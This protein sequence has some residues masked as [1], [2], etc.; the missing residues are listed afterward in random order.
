MRKANH[1]ASV[2]LLAFMGAVPSQAHALSNFK[3]QAGIGLQAFIPTGE[4][5]KDV[6]T[7]G[8]GVSGD[9]AIVYKNHVM[10]SLVFA[11]T[12]SPGDPVAG[13][14]ATDASAS[15]I[16]LPIA[17]TIQVAILTNRPFKPYVGVGWGAYYVRE[18]L[19]FT[20]PP[21]FGQQEETQSATVS[22]F[23]LMAGVEQNKP[24][25][26]FGEL[27]YNKASVFE[28]D[29]AGNGIAAGGIRLRIGYRGW[30]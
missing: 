3:Y 7:F 2:L 1:T 18:K 8:V 10:L 29:D 4:E 28:V 19:S 20:G 14:L 25:R 6:Y 27:W 15:F 22:C 24:R 26:I 12:Y 5:I 17:A 23:N 11:P 9:A 16:T 30:L 13:P 21:P